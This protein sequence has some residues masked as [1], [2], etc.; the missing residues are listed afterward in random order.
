MENSP[1][2]F[3]NIFCDINNINNTRKKQISWDYKVRYSLKYQ[4]KFGM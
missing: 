3:Q 1:A 2:I 4:L